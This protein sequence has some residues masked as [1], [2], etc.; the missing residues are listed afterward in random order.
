[1]WIILFVFILVIIYVLYQKYP[2]NM[3]YVVSNI[4]NV[5]YLVRNTN[6]KLE[7]ANMLATLKNIIRKIV[8]YI[9]AKIN[10]K[11][12]ANTQRYITYKPYILTLESKIKTVEIK[13]TPENSNYTSYTVNKGDEIVFC[14]RSKTKP[15][16]IHDINLITYVL[17]HE[18]AHI[19]CPEYD[20]TP[21]FKQ[22]FKF[23][24]EEAI[25]M[26]IYTKINFY[27]HPHMYCGMN[28]NDS[29]I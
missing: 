25:E 6:D 28:I 27:L 18:I 23:L 4:D 13:E 19:A 7:A 22:I 15:Y 24:C 17:L 8:D 29:I 14:I 26:G 10:N 2:K 1:M 5:K 20:H 16:N 3:I 11:Q 12:F 9:M 21:L